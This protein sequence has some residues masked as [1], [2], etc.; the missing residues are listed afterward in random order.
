MNI[1]VCGFLKYKLSDIS[2]HIGNNQY[3]LNIL[4]DII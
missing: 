1:C 2:V 3:I 4:D